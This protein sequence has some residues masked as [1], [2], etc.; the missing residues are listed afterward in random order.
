MTLKANMRGYGPR[1]VLFL[2]G[3]LSD[4][5][6]FD[7]VPLWFSQSEFTFAQMDFRGYGLNRAVAG[8][9]SADEIAKDALELCDQLE[10][11][12]FHVVGHSM[13]GMVTQKM[14]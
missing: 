14:A 1:K 13:G 10:W 5:Q 7:T 3:W 2:H 4:H 11:Q 6:V 9:Y 12:N 8:N